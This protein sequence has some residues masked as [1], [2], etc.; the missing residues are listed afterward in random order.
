MPID[1]DHAIREQLEYYRARSGEYDQWWYREGRYDRG[2]TENERW[3]QESAEVDSA[4]AAFRPAGRILELACGTGIWSAKLVA[5]ASELTLV[6]GSREMLD[7]AR[8]RLGR[9][10][11]QYVQANLFEWKPKGEFD[12][13]F[14][15][16]WLSHVPPDRFFA[17]WGLVSRCLAR[18]GRVFFVDSR[19]EQA[20]TA[21]D[22]RLQ[23]P[24]AIRLERRLNDGRA[25]QIYKIFYD[26]PELEQQ[27]SELGWKISVRKTGRFFIHGQG[28]R[29]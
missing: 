8:Q 16:F 19:H 25:F 14:F 12:T 4:L 9:A 13:V 7:V 28:Q 21:I 10:D 22:H 11:V 26:P 17:F 29:K 6:D 27:L 2:V 1:Q 20:S 18:H 15:S 3:F 23:G 5:S 24:E